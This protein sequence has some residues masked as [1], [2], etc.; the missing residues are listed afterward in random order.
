MD[1]ITEWTLP[2]PFIPPLRLSMTN[3]V[4]VQEV[5]HYGGSAKPPGREKTFP[6]VHVFLTF[7]V[8][9]VLFSYDAGRVLRYPSGTMIAAAPDGADPR[10]TGEQKNL[11]NPCQKSLKSGPVAGNIRRKYDFYGSGVNWIDARL[12]PEPVFS[13]PVPHNR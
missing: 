12:S 8:K 3:I 4:P 13:T 9:I 6:N 2:V 5:S 1:I 10:R 11:K 7:P